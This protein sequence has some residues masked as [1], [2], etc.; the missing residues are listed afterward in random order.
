MIPKVTHTQKR[1][2][3]WFLK[4]LQIKTYSPRTISQFAF[5]EATTRCMLSVCSCLFSA[6][7]ASPLSLDPLPSPYLYSLS[8]DIPLSIH[9]PFIPQDSK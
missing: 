8:C 3:K 6:V 5:V 1:E 9:E 7:I 4:T 2:V